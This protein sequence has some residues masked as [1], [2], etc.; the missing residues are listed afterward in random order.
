MTAEEIRR[1]YPLTPEIINHFR[2]LAEQEPDMTDEDNP[3]VVEMLE[4][5]YYKEIKRPEKTGKKRPAVVH[6]EP[7]VY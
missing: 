6:F 4:K 1:K 2:R 3:D 5:G 7:M